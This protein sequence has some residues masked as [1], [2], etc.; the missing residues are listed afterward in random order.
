MQS[1][2]MLVLDKRL[3]RPGARRRFFLWGVLPS[4]ENAVGGVREGFTGCWWRECA[5]MPAAQAPSSHSNLSGRIN[6]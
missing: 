3:P 1:N 5:P 2:D 6:W 4:G